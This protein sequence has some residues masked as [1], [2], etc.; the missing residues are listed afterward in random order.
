MM[1]RFFLAILFYHLSTIHLLQT[2]SQIIPDFTLDSRLSFI[3]NLR[4]SPLHKWAFWPYPKHG[5]LPSQVTLICVYASSPFHIPKIGGTIE[6]FLSS[7]LHCKFI[8]FQQKWLRH[9]SFKTA[10]FLKL[11]I[12]R[13]CRL[14]IHIY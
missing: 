14:Y 1:C 8:N 10:I 3:F 12:F 5:F 11:I 4:S 9:L 7:Y 2:L 6:V 13:A